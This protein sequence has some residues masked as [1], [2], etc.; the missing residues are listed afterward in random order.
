MRLSRPP[1][2]HAGRRARP[3][4]P[5]TR[6]L[7]RRMRPR[8]TGRRHRCVRASHDRASDPG[9]PARP[10]RPLGVAAPLSLSA[11]AARRPRWHDERRPVGEC[12]PLGRSANRS[13]LLRAEHDAHGGPADERRRHRARRCAALRSVSHR[14]AD[15]NDRAVRAAL[16]AAGAGNRDLLR[17]SPVPGR[18]GHAGRGGP[19]PVRGVGHPRDRERRHDRRPSLDRIRRGGE[20]AAPERASRWLV[21]AVPAAL[22]L[23][24]AVLRRPVDGR[25][26]G[27]L[28]QTHEFASQAVVDAAGS[29]GA[30]GLVARRTLLPRLRRGARPRSRGGARRVRDPADLARTGSA[31]RSGAG[32][33]SRLRV[34]HV[35]EAVVAGAR[36][37]LR[38]NRAALRDAGRPGRQGNRGAP[39]AVGHPE[40]GQRE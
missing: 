22:I 24:W 34:A 2:T 13:V 15:G 7:A 23:A 4:D 17:A 11:G 14:D 18:G 20:H 28:A 10:G 31:V 21:V 40:Q 9:R 39:G 1:R 12:R 38:G 27:F 37:P 26:F 30:V 6:D 29:R 3:G 8:R 19:D 35:G 36:P 25:W 33:V 32:R 16:R 5:W